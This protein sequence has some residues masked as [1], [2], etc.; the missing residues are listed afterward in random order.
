MPARQHNIDV[1]NNGAAFLV[2]RAAALVLAV[3]VA[4]FLYPVAGLGAIDGLV[5]TVGMALAHTRVAAR[6]TLAT[7]KITPCFW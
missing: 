2:A 1:V 4:A 3:V 6:K 5:N 7:Q